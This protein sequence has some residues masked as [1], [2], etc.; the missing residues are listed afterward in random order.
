MKF[1]FSHFPKTFKMPVIIVQHLSARSDSKWIK[2]LD[3]KSNLHIKEADEKE[4]IENGIV[5]IAPPNYHLLIETN[6]TFS[7]T[8]DQRVNYARP[9]IDVLFE[10]AAETY[11][12]KLIGIVLTGANNDGTN[13]IKKIKEVGGLVIIQDPETA[14]SFFMPASALRAVKPDYVLS[15]QGIMEVLI[16]I[17]KQNITQ[18]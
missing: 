6:R 3:E 5:Y 13:G 4:T 9:S 1:M 8:V 14:E 11:R 17:D 10:S 2:V 7:L 15:L 16:E 18:A 12:D